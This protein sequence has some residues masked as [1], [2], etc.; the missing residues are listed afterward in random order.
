[1]SWLSFAGR[2]P[3]QA[4]VDT[5]VLPDHLADCLRDVQATTVEVLG[6]RVIF[7]RSMFRFV[8]NWNVLAPFESGE[9]TIDARELRYQVDFRQLV[10]VDT[11]MVGVAS[12]LMLRTPVHPLLV[13]LP[14][15]WL[16]LVGASLLIGILRFERFLSRALISASPHQP[17]IGKNWR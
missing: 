15:M 12:I 6:K 13:V 3:F 8:S 10:L 11:V 16:W 1:M 17:L 14:L 4:E 5:A 9:L 2:L 7:A